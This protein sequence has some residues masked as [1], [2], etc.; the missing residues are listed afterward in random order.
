M[1]EVT[2]EDR[3]FVRNWFYEI[4][5]YLHINRGLPIPKVKRLLWEMSLSV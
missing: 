5:C 3:E 4:A 2:E 1:S